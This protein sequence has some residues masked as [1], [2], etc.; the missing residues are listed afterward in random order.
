MALKKP[1]KKLY[2]SL[3]QVSEMLDVP[4]STIKNWEKRFPKIQPVRNR[5]GN[6]QYTDK[7]V[8]LL[9]QLKSWIFDQKFAEDEI[10]ERIHRFLKDESA[11]QQIYLKQVLAEVKLEI[12][13][14]L[15]LLRKS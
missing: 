3:R 13:E 8:R 9:L 11:D 2:Y 12:K 10:V 1:S 5:A 14:I 6:R 4:E 15:Q 7:D